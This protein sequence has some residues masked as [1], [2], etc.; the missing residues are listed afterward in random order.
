MILSR[1]EFDQKFSE[2]SLKIAFIG[3]SNIG[4]S[5]WS[6]ALR[7]Y[8]DF[9]IISVDNEIEKDLGLADMSAM[10]SWMGYP[11]EE[12]YEKHVQQYLHLEEEKTHI[13]IPE[14]NFI[15]DTTGSVI[16]LSENLREF[17]RKNFLI[18]CFDASE[19]MRQ[20]MAALYF[21][22]P[23][24]IVWGNDFHMKEGELGID[25]LRRCYPELLNNRKKLYRELGDVFVAGEFSRLKNLK[26]KR[27]WE[28]LRLSLPK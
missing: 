16:Y 14:G 21:E 22:E 7:D 20:E 1:N 23:K 8:K 9:S 19:A 26:V 25:A 24:S 17:L 2:G 6:Q 10:A 18:V 28:V 4:K 15:L 27:F 3:M 12:K 5:H 11:F 13:Q